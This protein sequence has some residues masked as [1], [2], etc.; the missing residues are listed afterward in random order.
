MEISEVKNKTISGVFW[1]LAERFLAQ[2]I[3]FVVSI[4]LARI[5]MPDEYG[6]VALVMVF[7]NIMNSFVTNGLG[8]S[9][10][11]KKLAITTCFYPM[12]VLPQTEAIR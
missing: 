11:Q 4:V 7:I 8:T 5:L 9:L 1:R 10:I 2:L 3:S 12:V 6:I